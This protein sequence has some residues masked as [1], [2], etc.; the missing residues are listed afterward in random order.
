M[1][2]QNIHGSLFIRDIELYVHLGW[3][4]QER[5]CKQIVL[6]SINICFPI[7]PKGCYTDCL[8]D[9]ICYSTLIKKIRSNTIKKKFHLIEHLSKQIYQT[10]KKISPNDTKVNVY[11]TK[12][13]KIEGL[14][15][16]CFGYGDD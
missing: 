12:R 7:A 15:S 16:I 11:I 6:A 9:T 14:D 5:E 3:P 10:V 4:D 13:P 1:T 8:N 2:Q